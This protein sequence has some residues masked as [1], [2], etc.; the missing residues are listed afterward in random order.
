ME[1]G[2][3]QG[4]LFLR[5][6]VFMSGG[7][8]RRGSGVRLV[9]GVHRTAGDMNASPVLPTCLPQHAIDARPASTEPARDRRRMLEFLR[10]SDMV[11]K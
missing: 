10:S 3:E 8:E 6:D 2:G 5:G 1:I 11:N 4:E 7:I 9:A